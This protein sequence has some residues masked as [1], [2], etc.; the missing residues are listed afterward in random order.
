MLHIQSP[1]VDHQTGYYP[2]YWERKEQNYS[3]LEELT[4]N[5]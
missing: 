1:L 5:V 2:G 3:V 4:S